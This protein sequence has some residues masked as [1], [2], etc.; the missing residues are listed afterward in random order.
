MQL[1]F[2][3][4][5]SDFMR[6]IANVVL[7]VVSRQKLAKQGQSVS[8]IWQDPLCQK[9]S[10]KLTRVVK[11]IDSNVEAKIARRNEIR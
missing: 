7:L 10:K 3:C 2:G 5:R 11:V 9:D 1:S 4:V 6:C 8:R